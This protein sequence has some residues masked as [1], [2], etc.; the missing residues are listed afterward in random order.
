MLYACGDGPGYN[1]GNVRGIHLRTAS[2]PWGPWSPPELIFSP[3]E[4]DCRF[5]HRQDRTCLPPQPNPFEAAVRDGKQ[6][7][8]LA[9]GGE[10]AP[11]LLPS[12]YLKGQGE[13]ATL[14]FTMSTW[15]P[16]QV[17]LM[18]TEVKGSPP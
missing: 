2:R 3:D 13:T 4:G 11:F 6:P 7:E 10:Y 18:K 9:W 12:R 16:Y 1:P 8:K 17:V 14:Y 5:M 15:N